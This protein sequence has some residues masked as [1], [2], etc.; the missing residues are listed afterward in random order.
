MNSRSDRG[1]DGHRRRLDRTRLVD[2]GR[3]RRRAGRALPAGHF[4]SAAAADRRARK[5]S[6]PRRRR[7]RRAATTMRRAGGG[8]SQTLPAR[9][10]ARQRRRTTPRTRRSPSRLGFLVEIRLDRLALEQARD[11]GEQHRAAKRESRPPRATPPSCRDPPVPDHAFEHVAVELPG[12]LGDPRVAA[13]L[14]PDLDDHLRLFRRLARTCSRSVSRM[15]IRR[16][17]LR[18]ARRTLPG[19]APDRRAQAL[20]DRLLGGEIAVEVAG[21]HAGLV[22]H[23]R[24][25]R[26]MKAVA[27]EGAL[28]PFKDALPPLG[29]C[30]P[31]RSRQRSQS[32]VEAPENECSFS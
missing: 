31:A 16:S 9:P 21:A 11:Q 14:G 2:R 23:L 28:G 15:A 8:P 27:H 6:S 32:H 5:R 7:A 3:G 25:R 19:A 13:G 10:P 24:H 1:D 29:V 12:E 17:P 18:R 20:D 4:R 26:G 30:S 22:S